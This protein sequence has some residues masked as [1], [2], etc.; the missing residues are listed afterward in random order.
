MSQEPQYF[1]QA[2]KE[3]R[4]ALSLYS[5]IPSFGDSVKNLRAI[6]RALDAVEERL[7]A[8]PA[9]TDS[10]SGS[11]APSPASP[12]SPSSP[13]SPSSPGAP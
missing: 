11:P 4:Q 3:Y 6:Q 2:A 8:L 9:S 12:P 13:E 10:D 1:S 5:S 7:G